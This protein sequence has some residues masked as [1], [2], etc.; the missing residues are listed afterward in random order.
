MKTNWIS[1]SKISRK[2]FVIN[3]DGLVLGRLSSYIAFHL[4]GKHKPTYSPNLDCGDNFIVINAE[5]ILMTGNKLEKKCSGN[6]QD[7]QEDLKKLLIPKFLVV[8]IQRDF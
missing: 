5:K 2:W 4:M 3:A 8:N 7:T 6:I 1:K